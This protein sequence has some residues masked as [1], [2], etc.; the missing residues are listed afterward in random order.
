[1]QRRGSSML[2]RAWTIL[3]NHCDLRPALCEMNEINWHYRQNESAAKI[4]KF[5]PDGTR[6]AE[7]DSADKKLAALRDLYSRRARAMV[8][9]AWTCS[10]CRCHFD[11]YSLRVSSV[12]ALVAGNL[13]RHSQGLTASMIMREL[14]PFWPG[15]IIGSNGPLQQ[16]RKRSTEVAGSLRVQIAHRTSL[17]SVISM[18]SSTTTT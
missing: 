5:R 12:I 8:W 10:N 11:E 6:V 16:R 18:S 17:V 2:R 15:G 4:E 13:S 14:N 3:A 7:A 1:M 9:R